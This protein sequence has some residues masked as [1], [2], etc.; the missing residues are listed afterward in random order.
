MSNQQRLLL[1]AQPQRS[2]STSGDS[3]GSSSER[4]GPLISRSLPQK[5]K[6]VTLACNACRKR[7]ERCSGERPVCGACTRKGTPC[8]WPTDNKSNAVLKSK[9]DALQQE[10]D[11]WR[12]LYALLGRL[13]ESEARQTLARIRDADDPITVLSFATQASIIENPPSTSPETISTDWNPRLDAFNLKTLSESPIRVHAKPWTA[14][15]GDGLV[16]QLLSSF[17]IWDDAFF[18]PFVDRD[19]FLEDMKSGDPRKAKYCSPFLVNAIC[20]SRC[21][22]SARAKAFSSIS[23]KDV[24]VQFL[25]E[26]KKLLDLE[27]GRA[28]LPTVQG[29]TLMFTISAY[30]G[31]DRAGMTMLCNAQT[32]KIGSEEDLK[33]RREL[34]KSIVEWSGGLPERVKQDVNPTPQTCFLKIYIDE[35]LISILR[36]LDPGTIFEDGMSAK[37][38]CIQLAGI[39]T[40]IVEQYIESF[41]LRDYSCMACCGLYNS[42]ITLAAHLD[43]PAARIVFVK[44]SMMLRCIER[45][46]PM[47]KYILQ[48]I[49]AMAWAMGFEL[50]TESRQYFKALGTGK[51][52][53]QDMPLGFTLP[54][55][56]SVRE[57]LSA[58]DENDGSQMGIEMGLLLSKWS[59]LSV[60]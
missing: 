47:A 30:R 7:K 27:N 45:D 43:D 59:A 54:S 50:P 51:E 36:P 21:F 41:T 4:V 35:V 25:D 23:G 28:T 14:I 39:D 16:S 8:S 20:A 53:L 13:P 38:L 2:N 49:Q 6:S 34:N 3:N 37:R 19:A 26:A 17:F 18:Y 60:E 1:P 32:A 11:R 42:I 52:E 29:L 5:R 10:N 9:Y 12:E 24:G 58:D 56:G 33:R 22:T 48:G 31:V 44:A 40:G 46:Y 57:L 55:A 15:A